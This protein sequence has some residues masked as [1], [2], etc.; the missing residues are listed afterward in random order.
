M[1]FTAKTPLLHNLPNRVVFPI[2]SVSI[3]IMRTRLSSTTWKVIS[4]FGI[5][6]WKSE[7]K[8]NSPI[9]TDQRVQKCLQL[10]LVSSCTLLEGLTHFRLGL[11][12]NKAPIIGQQ[13][14]DCRRVAGVEPDFRK[15]IPAFLPLNYYSKGRCFSPSGTFQLLP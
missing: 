1:C 4:V 5:Y 14:A 6:I 8:R 7:A 12:G 11:R 10:R 2:S 15:N 13:I 9:F 3:F